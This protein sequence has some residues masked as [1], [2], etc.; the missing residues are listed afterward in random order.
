MRIATI[1]L[2]LIILTIASSVHTEPIH[3]EPIT[4]VIVSPVEGT[5]RSGETLSL[6]HI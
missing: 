5:V 4:V 1:A 2:M 6:I 3:T